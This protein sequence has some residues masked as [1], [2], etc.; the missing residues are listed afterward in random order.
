MNQEVKYELHFY[1]NF[2]TTSHKIQ[3][4][5]IKEEFTVHE[6]QRGTGFNR[7]FVDF[8]DFGRGGG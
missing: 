1:V 6:F 5:T 4:Q 8:E 7:Q 2:C 3:G